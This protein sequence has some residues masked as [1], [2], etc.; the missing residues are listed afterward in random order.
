MNENWEKTVDPPGWYLHL[1]FG[2]RCE[3]QEK[4]EEFSPITHYAYTTTLIGVSECIGGFTNATKAKVACEKD[5]LAKAE[6]L[7]TRIKANQG[8]RG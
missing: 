6:N 1:G 8:V 4:T 3:V 5:M 7:V 2:F